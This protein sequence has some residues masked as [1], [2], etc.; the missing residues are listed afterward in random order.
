MSFRLINEDD[1][2][3]GIF[4]LYSQLS[5]GY[6]CTRQYFNNFVKSLNTTHNIYVAEEDTKII[7][8]ATF[9]IESK[10]IRNGSQIMHIEDIVVDKSNRGRGLGI[11]IVKLLVEKSKTMG[12]YKVILNCSDEYIDFYKK[13]GFIT[14]GCHM[15]IYH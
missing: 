2:D 14:K 12:C 15:A 6:K 5:P 8:C 10:L 3:K 1:Y 4:S 13:N 7:A 9:L 11:D